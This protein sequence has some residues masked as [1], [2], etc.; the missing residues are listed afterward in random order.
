MVKEQ[1]AR[2]AEFV[3]LTQPHHQHLYGIALALCR[4][5]DQAADLTQE[6]LVRAFEAFDRFRPDAP[7]VPWLRRILR[8][9]F[10]DGFKTGRARHELSASAI[11]DESAT[12]EV[13]DEGLDPLAQLERAQ[14]S[15]WLEEEIARL[16]PDHRQVVMLCVMQ[17]LSFEE[18]AELLG[19]PVGTVA[20]R[21]ARARAQLRDRMLL[22]ARQGRG[23]IQPRPE[24]TTDAEDTGARTLSSDA[25][26]RGDEPA[27]RVKTSR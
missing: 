15:G 13:A 23:S 6:T 12:T 1:S 7:V 11:G 3:R 2:I 24:E 10:L 20:S 19:V 8:N 18:A 22:R 14:L 17:D 25:L 4:D 21:L 5:R 27:Q 26:A 16:G 9:L